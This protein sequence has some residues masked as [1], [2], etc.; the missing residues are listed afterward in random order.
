MNFCD[1]VRCHNGSFRIM[2]VGDVHEHFDYAGDG[3]RQYNDYVRLMDAALVQEKPDLVVM[4]GDIA[5]AD[6][7]ARLRV[8]IENAVAPITRHKIPFAVIFGNHDGE[9]GMPQKEHAKL[10]RNMP[11]CVFQAEDAVIGFRDDYFLPLVD[12]AGN[13]VFGFWFLNSGSGGGERSVYAY[14][15][16]EQLKWYEDVSA[17]LKT[18]YGAA[19]RTMVFQHIPVIEEYRLTKRVGPLSILY[20]GVKGLNWTKGKY[21]RLDKKKASG[22]LGEAPATPDINSGQF[23][24]WVQTGNVLAAFFGHDHMNDIVGKVDGITLGQ[25]KT[26]G[27]RPYGDGLQQGVRI[28]DLDLSGTE[29][30]MQTRM[31]RYRSFYGR[32]CESVRGMTRYLPDRWSTK[33]DVLVQYVLPFSAAVAGASFLAK[34][35]FHG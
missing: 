18:R 12:E 26:A 7:P 14:M 3:Q 28:I 29:P 15:T 16:R 33:I 31:V 20:D 30:Q 34:K 19:F 25:C 27:F 2:L 24:S 32:D 10:Y 22:Y 21:F 4:M 17:E 11:Y 1:S 5:N 35:I 8:T 23:D 9:S 13:A 6:G